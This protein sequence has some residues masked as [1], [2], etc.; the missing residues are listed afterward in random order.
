[1]GW[2]QELL[3]AVVWAFFSSATFAIYCRIPPKQIVWGGLNGSLMWA[4]YAILSTHFL[5]VV[6]SIF[7]ASLFTAA[8]AR[9]L[10]VW[11]AC[12][13][14]IFLIPGIFTLVPG[15]GIYNT[16]LSAI[17]RDMPAFM[18]KGFET[19][20]IAAA[21]AIGIALATLIPLPRKR[22]TEKKND[23]DEVMREK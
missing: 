12:P 4:I 20:Q 22:Q 18:S 8:A 17:Q 2:I 21:I 11:R 7:V 19:L 9:C 6:G 1:M 5:S 16:M 23:L 10:S 3:V 13:Q 15:A 14:T